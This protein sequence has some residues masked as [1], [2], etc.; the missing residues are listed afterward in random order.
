M[1]REKYFMVFTQKMMNIRRLTDLRVPLAIKNTYTFRYV[2][3]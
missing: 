3:R 2:K 1:R